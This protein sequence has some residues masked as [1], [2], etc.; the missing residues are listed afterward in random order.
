M[1]TD[2]R[3]DQYILKAEEFAQPILI[4]LRD[5]IHAACP[6]VEETLK[7]SMPHFMYKN[8]NL[9]GM[10]S[11]KKHCTFGL[12]NAEA[13][14]DKSNQ[15]EK[16]ER[17][18]MGNLGR[19]ASLKDLP[20]DKDLIRFI[21][22]AMEMI[23]QGVTKRK[24]VKKEKESLPLPSDFHQ[25]LLSN[26]SANDAFR[27]FSPSKKREYIEWIIEAKTEATRNKRML[28][29]IEWISEGKSRNWTMLR[30]WALSTVS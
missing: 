26:P 3:I 5:M 4:H 11:F 28:T 13:I 21:Q 27:N 18:A 25:A 7:W 8:A 30:T 23:D 10:A 24:V 20:K 22:K 14:E 6:D 29:A 16:G 9:C 17:S 1:K 19:I 12:W 2:K 15:L